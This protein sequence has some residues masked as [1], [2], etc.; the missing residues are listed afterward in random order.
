MAGRFIEF[1]CSA[2]STLHH[3][4]RSLFVTCPTC[5]A[6]PGMRCV[7]LRPGRNRAARV[8]THPTR[9]ALIKELDDVAEAS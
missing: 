5:E 8:S 9:D 3:I 1:R 6:V 4:P 2:C 7:D